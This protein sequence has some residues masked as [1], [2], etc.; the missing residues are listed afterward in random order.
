VLQN[1]VEYN[2]VFVWVSCGGPWYGIDFVFI[3]ENRSPEV[4]LFCHISENN[5]NI[6]T[7]KEHE[8]FEL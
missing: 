8:Q 7:H 6:I 3:K 5:E 2:W 4:Y 1:G